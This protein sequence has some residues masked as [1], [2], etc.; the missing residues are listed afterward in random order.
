MMFWNGFIEEGN[1]CFQYM[2]R[3]FNNMFHENTIKH[4]DIRYTSYNT[5]DYIQHVKDMCGREIELALVSWIHDEYH[6]H[7]LFEDKNWKPVRD[8]IYHDS[9]YLGYN[10]LFM[11]KEYY[12]QLAVE[13]GCRCE[14]CLL[15]DNP[16]YPAHFELALY[17][18]KN[19]TSDVLQPDNRVT[20]LSDC[21]LPDSEWN[22]K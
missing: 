17:G 15:S 10:K 16:E 14:D 2:I 5:R 3:H 20:V 8:G 4:F 11:Y 13:S 7:W 9:M 21:M 6:N 18:W 12:F 19:D 22:L 1:E